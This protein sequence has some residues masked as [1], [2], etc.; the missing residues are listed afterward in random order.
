MLACGMILPSMLRRP[1]TAAEVAAALAAWNAYV[2][3]WNRL[4]REQHSAHAWPI[5]RLDGDHRLVAGQPRAA[6]P[7]RRE[8]QF[9]R[10]ALPDGR[11]FDLR[12]RGAWRPFAGDRR[13]PLAAG[14]IRVAWLVRA[15]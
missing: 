1:A 6:V 10:F 8:H 13:Q 12:T 7:G 2:D 11:V 3:D 4:P 15:G 14:D 5:R 9:V